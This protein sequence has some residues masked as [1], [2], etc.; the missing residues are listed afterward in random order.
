MTLRRLLSALLLP[1]AVL[2]LGPAPIVSAQQPATDK[3]GAATSSTSAAA[4][5]E[6]LGFSSE[7]LERLHTAMQQEI[8]TKK[9]MAGAVT[10]LMRHGK[11]VDLKAYG[12]K[13][14]VSGAPMTTTQSF[15]HFP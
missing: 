5:P 6:S 12:K 3:S 11:L 4:K 14:L 7:R 1:V 2:A 10:L 13:D 8:D 9:T 15:E